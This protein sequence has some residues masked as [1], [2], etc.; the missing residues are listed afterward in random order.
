[1]DTS[2]QW[3]ATNISADF[4][5]ALKLRNEES[6]SDPDREPF[7]SLV[8]SRAVL[9]GI[10]DKLKLYEPSTEEDAQNSKL[11]EACVCLQ[12]G[13]NYIE[14]EET[15]SGQ[16]ELETCLTLL[17][18]ISDK[19]KTASVHIE[20]YNQLGAL[21][22]NRDDH[23]KALEFLLKAKGVYEAHRAASPMAAE[24]WLLGNPA[25]EADRA[26]LLEDL[27]THTLFYLAQVYG[28]T[29]H[30]H[31]SAQY[32]HDTLG[33]QLRA[34]QFDSVEWALNSATLSQYYV[35]TLNFLQARHCLAC[36]SLV[37]QRHLEKGTIGAT[38]DLIDKLKRSEAD[39]SRCWC[40]YAI[41]LLQASV[42]DDP[43]DPH[44]QLFRFETLDVA[45][46]ESCVTAEPV[47][48][49]DFAKGVFLFGQ[50]HLNLA[51]RYYTKD[52]Y[53]SDYI[54]IVQDHSSLFKGLAYFEPSDGLKCRMHKR[55]IDMLTE[56]LR[57][58]NVQHYLGPS[59]L[60]M[61]ELAGVYSEMVDLKIVIACNSPS[62][63]QITKINQL[64]ARSVDWYRKFYDT[65][66]DSKTGA[67]Y[68]VD[69]DILRSV[70]CARLYMAKLLTKTISP[71]PDA[72]ASELQ[73]ALGHYKW[74]V[75]YCDSHPDKASGVFTDD[76]L[77]VC[78]EM[79]TLLPQRIA[80]LRR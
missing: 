80:S 53:A 33:R 25:S 46:L 19:D 15:S 16:K 40:K 20:C 52:T 39:L 43:R 36:A 3:V 5:H 30:P 6:L 8:A 79:A 9:R 38:E 50:K 57:D 28:H 17:E 2:M 74:I 58:I 18:N 11:L 21:W 61:H 47:K 68:E 54:A 70:L 1:M 63:Q 23:Q 22:G 71:V 14:G 64:V 56:I 12:L 65:F 26:R 44:Q 67:L 32:C 69:N 42:R 24:Q 66:V 34:N 51:K 31:L 75:Q 4:Q 55:R 13:M 78:K 41:S 27:Y 49:Y 73:E 29:G 77:S 62:P 60:L 10:Q 76:E 59:R 45:G 35:G 37:L 48:D 7:K 72:Q